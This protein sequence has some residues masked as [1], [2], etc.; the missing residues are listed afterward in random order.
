MLHNKQITGIPDNI[1]GGE[2]AIMAYQSDED[3]IC[4]TISWQIYYQDTNE[5]VIDATTGN[6]DDHD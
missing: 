3:D 6:E 1:Y 2:Y 5:A 4:A